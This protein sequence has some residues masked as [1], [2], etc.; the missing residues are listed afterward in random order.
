MIE[1]LRSGPLNS[2]QDLGREGA[3]RWG[4]GRAGAMDPA[5][6]RL[7]NILVGNAPGEA[8]VE[9]AIFPFEIRFGTECA[10]AVTGAAAA[11]TLDGAPLPPLW[12]ARARPGQ[13][14]SLASPNLGV[15][16]Y[17]TFAGGL[18]VPPFLGSRSTDLKSG[19][20]GMGGQPLRP[21]QKLELRDHGA[22]ATVPDAGFGVSASAAPGLR[23]GG[24]GASLIRVI[25]AAEWPDFDGDSATAFTS[26]PWTVS[27]RVNR[28]GYVLSG[29]TLRLREPREL[30]SHGIV[31]G[32]VQVPPAGQPIV[33]MAEANTCGGYPK[34]ATV[35]EADL[36][37]LAQTRSGGLIRF[38]PVS[39]DEAVSAERDTEAQL[40]KLTAS[41][42][43]ARSGL[44]TGR[45]PESP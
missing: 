9:A 8:G 11:G 45:S 36:W 10:F 17:V 1:I 7:G 28:Q 13:V 18:D 40:E 38:E 42:S 3:L 19:F 30:L 29:P 25:A 27:R 32:V 5:A 15:F 34:I 43:L 23:R 39:W 31:P 14:L 26:E 35:I 44:G 16:A 4:V 24:D 37:R 6:L 12:A 21:G 33:Q 2:V 41:L 22:A 20:G